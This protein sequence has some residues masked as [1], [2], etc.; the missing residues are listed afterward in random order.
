MMD[1]FRRRPDDTSSY[2][3]LIVSICNEHGFPF[4]AASGQVLEGWAAICRGDIERGIELLRAGVTAW[5]ETGAR[6]WLP[7][8]L[9]LEAEAHSKAGNSD[10]A[11]QA[12]EQAIAASKET[13]EQWEIAEVL[14]MKARLLATRRTA[15]VEIEALLLE[16]IEIARRQQA[17]CWEL[18]A[19][20]DLA[21][22]WQQQGRDIEALSLLRSIYDQ[23]TEGF[24]TLD[25]LEAKAIMDSI[26]PGSMVKQNRASKKAGARKPNAMQSGRA[27]SSS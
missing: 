27:H 7:I 3:A 16:S 13:G 26:Q 14:R 10:A 12:I 19:A 25:L 15:D 22:L 11:L 6:L 20:C 2:A 23:F 24:D 18:R 8:Y 4:W 17:R 21:R 1:V 5:R 9:A